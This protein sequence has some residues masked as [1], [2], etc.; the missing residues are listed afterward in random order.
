MT[1]FIRV[2]FPEKSG[3]VMKVLVV[4]GSKSDSHIAEKV[5]KV[6]GDF[7]VSYDVEVASAHRNPKK[8]RN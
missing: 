2:N 5:T 6:P 7:G 3:G 8:L 1:K 4:M